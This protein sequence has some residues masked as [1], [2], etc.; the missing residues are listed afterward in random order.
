M[1]RILAAIA[2]V[3]GAQA[4]L[5]ADVPTADLDAMRGA[6][7]VLLGEIHDNPAH[8]AGQGAVI[9]AISPTAVVFEMLTPEMAEKLAE[10]GLSD[11]EVLDAAIGWEASGWPPIQIYAPV[12]E[13]LGDAQVFGAALPRETVRAAFADGAAAVFGA[14]A[15][16]FGLTEPLPAAEAEAREEMQFQA[17][18]EAMP[19]EM[20]GGMV[21]AQRLRDAR[22][23]QVALDA[24]AEFGA[25][26]VVIVGSG[27][28]RQ[29]W[30]MPA[31][32]ARAAPKVSVFALAFGEGAGGGAYDAEVVTSA[33]A[34]GDPCEVFRR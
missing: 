19:R 18:C 32:L 10:V 3:C 13:A 33:P 20:M 5:A 21:E 2:L 31:V 22:F 23:S 4:G 7:I 11:L 28:V 9:R 26:V 6:D 17:H 24:L 30:G 8:H 34:R 27:H 14:D 16:R 29:D 12:F 25:P 1:R 15:E